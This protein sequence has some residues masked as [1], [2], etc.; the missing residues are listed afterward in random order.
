MV[1]FWLRTTSVVIDFYRGHAYD[2]YGTVQETKGSDTL[3]ERGPMR[4]LGGSPEASGEQTDGSSVPAGY[5]TISDVVVSL[6]LPEDLLTGILAVATV[7]GK[8]PNDVLRETLAKMISE[9][10]NTPEFR[11]LADDYLAQHGRLPSKIVKVLGA[12]ATTAVCGLD[13]GTTTE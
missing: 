7:D 2:R 10:V 3:S 6:T 1:C 9:W 4:R 12:T 5:V 11:K 8:K 13:R